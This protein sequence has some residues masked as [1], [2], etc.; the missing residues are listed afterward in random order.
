MNRVSAP[1]AALALLLACACVQAAENPV[2][3]TWK[4]VSFGAEGL[5]WTLTV[6]EQYGKLSGKIVGDMGEFQLIDP[7]LDGATFAFQVSVDGKMYSAEGK[8]SGKS[9]QGAY[10]GPDDEGTFKGD[11]QP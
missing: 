10:K 3:G 6:T 2:V 8:I 4:I 9:I 5:K 7:K 11:K 1:L